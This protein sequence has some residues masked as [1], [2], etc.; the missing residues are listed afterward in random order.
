MKGVKRKAE[1]PT[2]AVFG[3]T[4]KVIN[5]GE[6]ILSF[7]FL[8]II[9]LVYQMCRV[10]IMLSLCLTFRGYFNLNYAYK[11]LAYKKNLVYDSSDFLR[12]S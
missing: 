7:L 3:Y 2:L 1:Q 5:N 4:N 10:A 12:F 11:R 9:F 6:K 8:S